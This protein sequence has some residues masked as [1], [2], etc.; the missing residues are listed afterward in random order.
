MQMPRSSTCPWNQTVAA[1]WLYSI[2]QQENPPSFRETVSL[3][4]LIVKAEPPNERTDDRHYRFER[5]PEGFSFRKSLKNGTTVDQELRDGDEIKLGGYSE[6]IYAK[7]QFS[8]TTVTPT[9]YT[10]RKCDGAFQ[11]YEIVPGSAVKRGSS[12]KVVT[13]RVIGEPKPQYAVKIIPGHSRS[14]DKWDTYEI[15]TLKALSHP[16][17]SRLVEAFLTADQSLRKHISSSVM[18]FF[19]DALQILSWN[20]FRIPSK[21]TSL[22]LLPF[23]HTLPRILVSIILYISIFSAGNDANMSNSRCIWG[24]PATPNMFCNRGKLFFCSRCCLP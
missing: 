23:C 15:S 3:L 10:F 7:R 20:I 14:A 12:G 4:Q 2:K 13:V 17:I 11:K 19:S 24:I 21:N 22:R 5:S 6:F 1:I 16:N 9:E 8:T 18:N